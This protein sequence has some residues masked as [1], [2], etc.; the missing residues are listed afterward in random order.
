MFPYFPWMIGPFDVSRLTTL[1]HL[2]ELI[3]SAGCHR[4]LKGLLTYHISQSTKPKQVLGTES[5]RPSHLLFLFSCLA[6][7]TSASFTF[8]PCVSYNERIETHSERI[9]VNKR[10]CKWPNDMLILFWLIARSR[11]MVMNTGYRDKGKDSLLIIVNQKCPP[12]I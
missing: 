12:L 6:T 11:F 3:Q 1:S 4:R 9:V 5:Y 2:F 7:P 10:N 8:S